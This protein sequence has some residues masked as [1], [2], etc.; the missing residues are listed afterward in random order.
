MKNIIQED[1]IAY[2]WLLSGLIDHPNSTVIVHNYPSQLSHKPHE[3]PSNFS[4]VSI[5]RWAILLASG[6]WGSTH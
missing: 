3:R 1:V 5:P 2:L 4:T 6:V